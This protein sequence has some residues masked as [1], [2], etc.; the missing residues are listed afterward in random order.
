MYQRVVQR[1]LQAFF[2]SNELMPNQQSAYRQHHSTETAV[3]KVYND[4]LMAA[5]SGLVSALCLLDL[6]AAFDTVVHDLLLLRLERQ[7]SLL[8]FRSCLSGRSYRV[9]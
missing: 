5:E 6:T 7:F 1:R 8:W 2:G 3:L 9:R 4:L